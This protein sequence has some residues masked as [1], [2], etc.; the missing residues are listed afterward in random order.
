[1]L[2]SLLEK[3][4]IPRSSALYEELASRVDFRKCSDPAFRLLWET[5]QRWFGSQNSQ[6]P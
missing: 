4:R 6:N 1:M 3:Q 5:L 2:E